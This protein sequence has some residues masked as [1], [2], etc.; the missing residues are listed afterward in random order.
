MQKNKKRIIE[1]L[2]VERFYKTVHS[3]RIKVG[4][5]KAKI[6]R[7]SEYYANGDMSKEDFDR[8]KSEL[9]SKLNSM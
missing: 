1:D 8:M 2:M 6:R 5:I 9:E 4:I 3:R 7:I